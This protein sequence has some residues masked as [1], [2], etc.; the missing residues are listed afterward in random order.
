MKKL[1]NQFVN[2]GIVGIFC[3]LIDFGLTVGLNKAGVHYLLSALAGF[4]A[5]VVTNYFLTFKFVF[6]RKENAD[7]RKEFI[8]FV[9]LSAIGCGINEIILWVIVDKI[10]VSWDWLRN[11]VPDNLLVPL[12]KIVASGMV[13]IYN[14]ITRKL[15]FEQKES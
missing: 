7:K 11:I 14:F 5:S 8:A 12:A 1:I 13:M 3:F 6:K 4:V 15:S 9:L 10:Y 2:F